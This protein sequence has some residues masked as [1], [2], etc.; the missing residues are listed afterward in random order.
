MQCFLCAVHSLRILIWRG[1]FLRIEICLFCCFYFFKI[2]CFC[3]QL[4]GSFP[5]GNTALTFVLGKENKIIKFQLLDLM[6][7]CPALVCYH[8][9]EHNLNPTKL[10][11]TLVFI[12]PD[13]IQSSQALDIQAFYKISSQ[14]NIPQKTN[15]VKLPFL[16]LFRFDKS[17]QHPYTCKKKSLVATAFLLQPLSHV[18]HRLNFNTTQWFGFFVCLF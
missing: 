1:I 4:N 17:S 7:R 11:S 8:A 9:S 3:G 2:K 5:M 15:F 16:Q 12:H 14:K 13:T 18:R 6:N 10:N